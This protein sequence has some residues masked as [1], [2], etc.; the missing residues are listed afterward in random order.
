[1]LPRKGAPLAGLAVGVCAGFLVALDL[2][3]ANYVW[4]RAGDMAALVG[5]LALVYGLPGLAIGAVA[6]VIAGAARLDRRWAVFLSVA[7][8]VAVVVFPE[9]LRWCEACDQTVFGWGPSLTRGPTESLMITIGVGLVCAGL[10][11]ACAT[12]ALVVARRWRSRTTRGLVW[13]AV[14]ALIVVPLVWSYL[15]SPGRGEVKAELGQAVAQPRPGGLERVI[16][17]VDDGATWDVIGPLMARGDLPAIQHLVRTGVSGE[18]RTLYPAL[19]PR[20]WTSMVTGRSPERHGIGGFI[21]Y[22]FPGMEQGIASFPSRARIKLADLLVRFHSMG[23]GS[24]RSLGPPGRRVRALWDIAGASGLRV[25]LVSWLYTWPAEAVNGFAVADRLGGDERGDYVFPAELQ[26]HVDQVVDGLAEPD[27]ERL[28]AC[29]TE[30]IAQDPRASERLYLLKWY[31]KAD[32]RTTAVARDLAAAFDPKLLAVGL[33]GTD[34]VEHRFYCEHSLSRHPDRYK[35][36]PYLEAHTSE[37]LVQCLGCTVERSYVLHDSLIG[38]WLDWVGPKS[39]VILVS[40]HGHDLTGRAHTFGPPG[41]FI[42]SGGPFKQGFEVNGAS[43]LDIAPT[44]LHLLGLPVPQ[45]MEGRVLAEA[46]DPDWVAANPVRTIKTYEVAGSPGRAEMPAVDRRL[47]D[48]L[49]ALG[50]IQ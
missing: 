12:L 37:R 32:Q 40:D 15:G 48:E 46:L 4:E 1:M 18:L 27:L 34:K 28:I 41:I 35:M 7:A 44:V 2:A 14:A 43:V 24:A 20:I 17:I 25:G 9:F 26:P 33:T 16:L 50:Y 39:A 38:V 11:A 29:P 23:I 47:L 19:S 36:A 8:T 10:G 31:I 42:A 13:S 49:K 22:A 5:W 30:E 45:D 21:N 3:R 6:A